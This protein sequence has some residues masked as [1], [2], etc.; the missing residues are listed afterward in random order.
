MKKITVMYGAD[1]FTT[2]VECSAT[3]GDIVANDRIQAALGYGDNVRALV[4]GV[5]MTNSSVPSDGSTIVLETRCNEKAQD[6]KEVS[7]RFGSDTV[8]RVVAYSTTVGQLRRD[9]SIRASLGFG[10]NVRFLLNGVALD[11]NASAPNGCTLVVETRCN[12]KAS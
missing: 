1:R 8:T 4:N 10:D 11:D 3:F 9:E 2:E 5:E 6:T 7:I 12:E